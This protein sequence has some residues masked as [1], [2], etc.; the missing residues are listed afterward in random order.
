MNEVLHEV[1]YITL[2][3]MN[4]VVPKYGGST[5]GG[6]SSSGSKRPMSLFDIADRVGKGLGC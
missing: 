2:M 3:M 5:E 4:A 6:G 1:P